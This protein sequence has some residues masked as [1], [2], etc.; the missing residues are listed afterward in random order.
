M[1]KKKTKADMHKQYTDGEQTH[2]NTVSS[3]SC[4]YY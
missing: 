3:T 4:L 1:M 2:T